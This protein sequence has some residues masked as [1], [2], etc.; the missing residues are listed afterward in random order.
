MSKLKIT[1]L[2]TNILWENSDENIKEINRLVLQN[3]GADLFV[4]PEMFNTGFTDKVEQFAEDEVGFTLTSLKEI[5]K[6]SEAAIC[7]SLLMKDGDKFYNT[8]VFVKPDGQIIK[9]NKRHIFRIGNESPKISSGNSRVIIN[10]LGVRIMPQICYDLRF[11]VW[12]RNADD[13]DVIIYVANWPSARRNIFDILLRA[14]A[15]ENLCFVVAN[16]RVGT[17]GNNIIYNGGTQVIDYRGEIM[18]KAIDNKE[19]VLKVELDLA[20]LEEFK[21][22]FPAHLDRDNFQIFV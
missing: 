4:L 3:H 17:D 2:Q 21:K 1:L 6:I 8:F 16:N 7:G 14:R 11:P 19:D 18:A 22:S 13:Y 12:N 15:I 5:A 10:Y 20:E 9:Y